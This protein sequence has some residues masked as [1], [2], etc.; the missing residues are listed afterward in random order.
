MSTLKCILMTNLTF[1]TKVIT[2]ESKLTILLRVGHLHVWS[3]VNDHL[4]RDLLIN[5]CRMKTDSQTLALIDI[6]EQSFGSVGTADFLT[7]L[8]VNVN[9]IKLLINWILLNIFPTKYPVISSSS[10]GVQLTR[11]PSE[12]TRRRIWRFSGGNR[13]KLTSFFSREFREFCC[14]SWILLI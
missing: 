5:I 9:L 1:L 8:I 13:V 11:R 10:G 6:V 4:L 7:L 3:I 14:G 12:P 2:V